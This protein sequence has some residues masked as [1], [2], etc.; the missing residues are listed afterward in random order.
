M[1]LNLITPTDAIP[2]SGKLEG[3]EHV[4]LMRVYYADTD[5]AGVMYHANYLRFAERARC[6]MMRC[7]GFPLPQVLKDYGIVFAIRQ[8]T[9]DF[10]KPAWLDDALEVRTRM[11]D[12]GASRMDVEHIMTCG[13]DEIARI[14]ITAVAINHDAKAVRMPDEMRRRLGEFV[15]STAALKD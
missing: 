11:V 9:I 3:Y 5:A 7:L 6:E 2:D 10:I 4:M 15:M 8:C 12:I 1:T 13:E 14:K